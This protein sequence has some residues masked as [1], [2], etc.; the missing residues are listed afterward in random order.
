MHSR[1]LFLSCGAA[2]TCSRGDSLTNSSLMLHWDPIPDCSPFPEVLLPSREAIED[3]QKFH[4][5]ILFPFKSFSFRML[6]GSL[7]VRLCD[8]A[9]IFDHIHIYIYIIMYIY[10]I[11]ILIIFNERLNIYICRFLLCYLTSIEIQY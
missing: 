10:N 4:N 3:L 1:S 8:V 11:Y 9:V 7:V 6:G 5:H 2:A